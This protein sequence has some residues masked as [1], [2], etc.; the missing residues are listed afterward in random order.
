MK[1]LFLNFIGVSSIWLCGILCASLAPALSA[2]RNVQSTIRTS[3][4]EIVNKQG[5]EVGKIQTGPQGAFAMF[6][7]PKNHESIILGTNPGLLGIFSGKT[8]GNGSLF[9]VHF[10]RKGGA[11]EPEILMSGRSGK[12]YA[13]RVRGGSLS[14]KPLGNSTDALFKLFPATRA[15]ATKHH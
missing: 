3:S 4:I 7:D 6:D 10:V 9:A 5:D 13:M 12:V 14:V 11:A 1:R 2:P 15:W 8:V